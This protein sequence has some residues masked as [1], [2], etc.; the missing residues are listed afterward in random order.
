MLLRSM[1]LLKE[2]VLI[3]LQS[4]EISYVVAIYGFNTIELRKDL[5]EFIN[6]ICTL[7]ADPICFCG[8]YNSVL[9]IEDRVNGNPVTSAEFQDL[10][11][12]I[13]A[14][15]LSEVRTIGGYY[16]WCNNQEGD[17]RIV[18]KIDR[19]LVSPSWKLRYPDVIV[20]ML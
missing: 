6:Q 15:A 3:S 13:R 4:G 18:S 16:T 14:N 1:N 9:L 11:A 19:C 8:D 10:E 7:Y 17:D 12:C 5:W 2:F 20:E